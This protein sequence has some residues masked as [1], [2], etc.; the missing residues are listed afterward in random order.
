M[1][2][3][4]GRTSAWRDPEANGGDRGAGRKGEAVQILP[5]A[6]FKDNRNTVRPRDASHATRKLSLKQMAKN[7]ERDSGKGGDRRSQSRG[8]TVKLEDLGIPK[9][10]ASRAMQL[11]EVNLADVPPGLN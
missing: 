1:L 10:R 4:K 2:A 9:D 6:G 7:G 8:A 5:G 11:A 3:E